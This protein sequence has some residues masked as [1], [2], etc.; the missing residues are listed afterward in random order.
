MTSTSSPARIAVTGHRGLP[1]ETERLVDSGIRSFVRSQPRPLIGI[2]CLADGADQVFAQAILDAGG[3][4][5]VIVPAR[6]YRAGLPNETHAVYDRL[7]SQAAEVH[8]L[9]YTESTSDAHMAA[10]KAMLDQANALVAVWDGQPARGYGG[11]ADV[12][13]LA[14]QRDLPVY[15]VWPAGARRTK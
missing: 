11:T 12:V 10:S 4:L 5:D 1:R 14:R 2:S 7:M 3:R 9:P 13:A 8:T 15:I 6:E